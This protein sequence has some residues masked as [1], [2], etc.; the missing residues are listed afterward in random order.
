MS[1]DCL[2]FGQI[3]QRVNG[4]TDI[5]AIAAI[6]TVTL[7]SRLLVMGNPEITRDSCNDQPVCKKRGT[8]CS[9]IPLLRHLLFS[10]V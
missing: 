3:A 2:L 10:Q 1:N 4:N 9:D 7:R 8:P 5:S 6:N